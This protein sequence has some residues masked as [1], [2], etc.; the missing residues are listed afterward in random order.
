MKAL[1]ETRELVKCYPLH[2]GLLASR[3]GPVIRA[4]DGVSLSIQAGETLGLVGESGCGKSTF[5]RLLLKLEEPT[6]G[7]IRF[8]G[9]DITRL[10]EAEFRPLRRRMQMIFQD[11]FASLNPRM[12]VVDIIG[13][14]LKIHRLAQGKQLKERVGE[15][16][17]QVGLDQAAM[18]K[19]PHE[20]SGGQ[21]QRIGIA[22]ALAVEPRFIVADEPVSALDV[23]VRA[24]IINLLSELQEVHGLTYL[25]IAHD[26]PLVRY[27]CTRV[28]VMYFGRIVEM[29][30]NEELFTNPLHPYTCALMSAA[31]VPDPHSKKK[32]IILEGEV[33]NPAAPPEGCAFSPR[34][35]QVYDA[36]HRLPPVLTRKSPGHWTACHAVL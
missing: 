35:P 33:P 26:L 30:S 9:R 32:K 4:V 24:Q 34:C 6:A 5:G 1:L 8:E 25:F 14:A 19:Y 3:K 12:R 20:F 29:A 36:C 18:N 11:P 23:S 22:R 31:P 10:K 27:F 7:E 16:L 13:E 2:R 15:L 21:R 17:K 28:V